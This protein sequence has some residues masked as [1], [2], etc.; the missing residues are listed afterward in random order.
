MITPNKRNHIKLIQSH[1]TDAITSN[2]RNK[3]ETVIR[4]E[5]APAKKKEEEETG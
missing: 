3:N 1:Q 4:A 2:S 5:Q